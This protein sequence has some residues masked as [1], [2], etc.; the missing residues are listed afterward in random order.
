METRGSNFVKVSRP[1]MRRPTRVISVSVNK[2][3]LLKSTGSNAAKGSSSITIDRALSL[4]RIFSRR[5][6]FAPRSSPDP[7]GAFGS[8][9]ISPNSESTCVKASVTQKPRDSSRFKKSIKFNSGGTFRMR[10]RCRGSA[11]SGDTGLKKTASSS[12][13]QT[14]RSPTKVV[15]RDDNS[16]HNTFS[17]AFEIAPR[18]DFSKVSKRLLT[19]PPL[20]SRS[21]MFTDDTQL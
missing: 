12:S 19:K 1:K 11:R 17:T 15:P 18:N 21:L 4:S 14:R 3:W 16:S 2:S 10:S 9:T 5:K 20:K 7:S 13:A 6:T 8:A